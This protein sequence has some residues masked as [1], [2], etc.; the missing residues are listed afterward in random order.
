MAGAG[1]APVPVPATTGVELGVLKGSMVLHFN[2]SPG[3]AGDA[4]GLWQIIYGPYL[5]MK[6]GVRTKRVQITCAAVDTG[7]PSTEVTESRI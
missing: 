7:T 1:L 2:P 4:R 5:Q 6:L 3:K